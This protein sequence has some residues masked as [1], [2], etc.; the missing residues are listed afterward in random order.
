MFKDLTISRYME[1]L[2]ALKPLTNH[3]NSSSQ[4]SHPIKLQQATEGAA[5]Y[6]SMAPKFFKDITTLKHFN[7]AKYNPCETA[8]TT[9]QL[10]TVK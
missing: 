1:V 7:A 4:P 8:V 10:L 2:P 9:S 3:S 6:R 5:V